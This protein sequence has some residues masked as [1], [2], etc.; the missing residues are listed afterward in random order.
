MTTRW[1]W[2]S[3][4]ASE[5]ADPDAL[6][7]VELNYQTSTSLDD[8][9]WR[10]IIGLDAAYTYAPTY[11]EVLK[12]YGNPDHLPAF[13]IEASYEGE[14]DYTGPETLRRQEYWTHAERSDG[15]VLRQQVHLAVPGRMARLPRHGSGRGR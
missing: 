15:A 2:R 8:P 4:G 13:M 12:A 3:P 5:S 6:Q 14:H 9:R 11:A 10:G 7:T 1:R